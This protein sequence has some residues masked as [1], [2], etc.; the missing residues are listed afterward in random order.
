MYP[1]MNS[2]LMPF[3][4]NA[5]LLVLMQQR[6][7]RRHIEAR[8]DAMTIED[9]RIRGMP[10]RLP[11]CPQLSRPIDLPPSRSSF[12]S[13]SLSNERATAHFAPPGQDVGRSARPARA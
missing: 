8:P 10:T 13:W 2:D 11:Y 1:A 7:D 6:G 3:G 9:P 5:T 4:D 12:V